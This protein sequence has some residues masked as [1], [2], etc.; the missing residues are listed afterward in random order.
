M[1]MNTIKETQFTLNLRRVLK[2]FVSLLLI[3]VC[4]FSAAS[5]ITRESYEFKAIDLPS[6]FLDNGQ[7]KIVSD[8][9]ADSTQGY[10]SYGP[11]IDLGA[12]EYTFIVEYSCTSESTNWIDI[13]SNQ[14]TKEHYK[15][16]L[17]SEKGKYQCTVSFDQPQSGVEF[18]VFFGGLGELSVDKISIRE[19]IQFARVIIIAVVATVIA[20]FSLAIFS[21]FYNVSGGKEIDLPLKKRVISVL[22]PAGAFAFT[23]AIM[24]AVDVY[25]ANYKEFWFSFLQIL[26]G[27]IIVFCTLLLAVV[28]LALVLNGASYKAFLSLLLCVGIGLYLQG[29]FLPNNYG[30]LDGRAIEWSNYQGQLIAS[31]VIWIVCL[32]GSFIITRM[33]SFSLV[34]Y[35]SGLL[36]AMQILVCAMKLFTT[37]YISGNGEFYFS[38][39]DMFTASKDK[40]VIVF[41]LDTFDRD[42]FEL[43]IEQEPE[44]K[45][46]FSDFVYFPDMAAGGAPTHYGIPCIMTATHC[47]DGE[48]YEQYKKT[49]YSNNMLFNSMHEN[50]YSVCVYSGNEY[51]SNDIVDDEFDNVE[52]SS[53]DIS[54]DA[55]LTATFYRL[56]LFKYAPQ[57]L[58]PHFWLSSGEFLRFAQAAPEAKDNYVFDDVLFYQ[59]M[60]RDG[61]ELI[62]QNAFR[63]Y[64][65]FG[66]HGPYTITEDIQRT[67]SGSLEQACKA[68]LNIVKEYITLLK[69]AGVYDESLLIIM[70]DHG[71]NP[72]NVYDSPLFMIKRPESTSPSLQTNEAPVC[73]VDIMPTLSAELGLNGAINSHGGTS[74][75]N[76]S[77]DEERVRL[78]IAD[79]TLTNQYNGVQ[80]MSGAGAYEIRG[81]TE[82]KTSL[83]FMGDAKEYYESGYAAQFGY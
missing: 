23:I 53:L 59:R 39:D 77:E 24:G 7:E 72:G 64:H 55:G 32:L 4:L 31:S 12:K 5:F 76:V 19:E 71:A 9:F 18:R 69:E 49:A 60:K 40:N 79:K 44:Y 80:V 50:N 81:K 57:I 52:R 35:A 45:T 25:T 2:V 36:L 34:N 65:L 73:F 43:T 70:A 42:F 54:S 46:D 51:F 47:F 33:A 15:G 68:S 28:L 37:P 27:V 58:K 62:N 41:I 82:D 6:A 56:V 63:F 21:V 20:A 13:V 66:T 11:Y 61:L 74:V 16:Y 78:H 29:N 14:G 3:I 1:E 48:D 67:E 22:L 83:H 75:F 10:L 26:P 30:V 17:P 38:T 8:A